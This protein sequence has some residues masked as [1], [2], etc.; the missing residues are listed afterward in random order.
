MLE[1]QIQGHCNHPDN[2]LSGSGDLKWKKFLETT[3]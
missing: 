1:D 3:N 2:R